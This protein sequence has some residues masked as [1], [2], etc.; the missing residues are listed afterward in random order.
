MNDLSSFYKKFNIKPHNTE[1]YE[2][3]FTHSSFNNEAKTAHHDYERLE[4]LGDSVLD[5]VIATSLFKKFPNLKEGELTKIKSNLVQSKTLADISRKVDFVKYIRHGHSLKDL[6]ILNNN[7]ILED[8]FEAVV[9]AIFLDQGIKFTISFINKIFKYEIN[10][11]ASLEVTDYKSI[12]QEAMQAE[13]RE[14]VKYIVINQSGPAHDKTFE[15]NVYFNDILLGTGVGKSKKEAEQ[16]AAK[17][18]LSKKA[19]N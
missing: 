1:L 13:F 14:S 10:N 4:F 6:D 2:V 15:V 16:R 11:I 9:A 7:S 3:A 17:D 8:V 12:L 19:P 18:A 5:F